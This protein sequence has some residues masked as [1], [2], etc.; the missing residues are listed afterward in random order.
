MPWGTPSIKDEEM[1]MS[2]ETRV[3]TWEVEGKSEGCYVIEAKGR[4]VSRRK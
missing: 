2:K 4:E 3:S 1:R